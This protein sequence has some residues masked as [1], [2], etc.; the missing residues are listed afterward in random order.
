MFCDLETFLSTAWVHA[1]ELIFFTVKTVSKDMGKENLPVSPC[2]DPLPS[3]KLHHDSQ[4]TLS[5]VLHWHSS[6]KH[7]RW[8]I[9]FF[10]NRVL[11]KSLIFPMV[12]IIVW[13]PEMLNCST[14]SCF[15]GKTLQYLFSMVN[16]M[17]SGYKRIVGGLATKEL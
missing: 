12:L 8:L 17:S 9:Q 4:V 16:M 2:Q 7:S 10:P 1:F 11:F 13:F 14:F 3:Q 6:S 5:L 15:T